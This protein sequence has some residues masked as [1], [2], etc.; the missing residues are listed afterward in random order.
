MGMA[1]G[2]AQAPAPGSG[3]ERPE[4]RRSPCSDRGS[5]H[6]RPAGGGT[7][8]QAYQDPETRKPGGRERDKEVI[9]HRGRG[10]EA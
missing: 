2:A 9:G 5:A 10:K 8:P 4:L 7:T 3:A 1:R 6:Q